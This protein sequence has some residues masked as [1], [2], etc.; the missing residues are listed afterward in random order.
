MTLHKAL[1]FDTS[2]PHSLDSALREE[3]EMLLDTRIELMDALVKR[4]RVCLG[5]ARQLQR[6]GDTSTLQVIVSVWCPSEYHR[7]EGA[8]IWLC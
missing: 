2:G 4:R 6:E 7:G 8:V 3:K 5:C 1:I